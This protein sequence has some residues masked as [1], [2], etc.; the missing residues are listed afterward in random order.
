MKGI[1]EYMPEEYKEYPSLYAEM[2][3]FYNFL[4]VYQ[5]DKTEN[6]KAFLQKAL[7]DLLFS[8]KHRVVEG[9]L[10]SYEAGK[11]GSYV[12]GLVHD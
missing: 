4:E 11:M 12:K 3:D 5:E 2:Q 9:S 10:T 8:I 7:N 6:N 1:Y